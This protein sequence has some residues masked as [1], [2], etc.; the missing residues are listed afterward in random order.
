MQLLHNPAAV[1]FDRALTN[2][3]AQGNFLVEPPRQ[4]QIEH[5][6]FARRQA[7]GERG[8][9]GLLLSPLGVVG[10]GALDIGLYS[11]VRPRSVNI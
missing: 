11:L 9:P 4:H 2:G 1:Q 10:Y 8:A 5:R 3:Q 7:G 6:P